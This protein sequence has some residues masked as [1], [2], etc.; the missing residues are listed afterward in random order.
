MKST[1]ALCNKLKKALIVTTG[2]IAAL[3][4]FNVSNADENLK[5]SSEVLK[6]NLRKLYPKTSFQSVS[7]AVYPGIYEVVMGKNVIYTDAN[8]RYFM[9]GHLFDMHEQKDLTEFRLSEI[10]KISFEGLP[11]DA[12]IVFKEG[13]G[14][15]QLAV[16]SDPDCPY[17]KR[18]EPELAKLK[19]VTIYL[20][21]LPLSMHPEASAKSEAVWCSNDR[22]SSWRNLLLNNKTAAEIKCPTPIQQVASIAKQLNISGTP[23][24]VSSDGRVKPGAMDASAIDSWINGGGNK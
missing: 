20:Y 12:A 14:T 15:R 9:F 16:F 13:K 23:T 11:K 3:A 19:D 5:D 1:Y 4:L 18:L 10:N 8:G 21:M 6:Q 2:L 7:P 24:L 17:C 22:A